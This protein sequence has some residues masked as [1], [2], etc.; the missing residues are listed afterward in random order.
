MALHHNQT[1]VGSAELHVDQSHSEQLTILIQNLLQTSGHE[2]KSLNAVAISAGPGSYTGLRIGTS[3]AKGLC[4]ALDIPLIAVDTLEAMAYSMS[5]FYEDALLCPMIDAR[6][7]EVYC[8]IF[9]TNMHVIKAV[10]AKVIDETAFASLLNGQRMIF[11]GNGS[12]KCKPHI[13]H[14]NAT[15]VESIHPNAKYLGELAGQEYQ[16]ENFVDTAYFEPFYLKNYQAIKSS[17]TLV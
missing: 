4:Y 14:N 2:A 3:T 15:F 13:I 16:A 5:R 1:L 12:T 11:F 7:M 10:Q 17:K 9:D 6:R 8:Q